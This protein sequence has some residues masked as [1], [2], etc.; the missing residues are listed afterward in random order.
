VD[1]KQ[2]FKTAWVQLAPG[3]P[4]PVGEYGFHWQR[5]WRFDFAFP[6]YKIAVEVEGGVY[7]RG[8]H[9]RP[10]GYTDDIQKYNTAL[11]MGW[12]VFR[13]T[14]KQLTDD[15]FSAVL[16]VRKALDGQVLKRPAV[17][18]LV[19]RKT[20]GLKWAIVHE[21]GTMLHVSDT[22][23]GATSI[24]ADGK[25]HN[26]SPDWLPDPPDRSDG[27]WMFLPPGVK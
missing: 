20:S 18:F 5:N 17:G 24:A 16:A 23:K 6:Q 1:K 11:A 2:L 25:L 15:P 19:R 22:I 4:E 10:Q 3:C 13:F 26:G 9:V 12:R 21:N 8:R 7:S 27:R 14:T